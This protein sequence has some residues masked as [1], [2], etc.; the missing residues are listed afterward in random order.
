MVMNC[1]NQPD[2]WLGGGFGA[3][4]N[5]HPTIA[6]AHQL[7]RRLVG[8]HLNFEATVGFGSWLLHKRK[9]PP[10]ERMAQL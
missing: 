9:L 1:K 5:T 10:K 8:E 3:I 2:T 4:S 6:I 7:N